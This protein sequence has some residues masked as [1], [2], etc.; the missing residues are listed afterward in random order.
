MEKWR[1][2]GEEKLAKLIQ[3]IEQHPLTGKIR[4][5]KAAETLTAR[6]EAAGQLQALRKEQAE[7]VGRLQ[8][9]V[10]EIERAFNQ[11]KSALA[12]ASREYTQ[13][14]T[15]CKLE[16]SGF[17]SQIGIQQRIL[18]ETHD[19]GIDEAILFFRT[20]LDWLR[21]PGRIDSRARSAERNIF[22]MSKQICRESNE[23]GVL[24][25][26]SYCQQAI[27]ALEEFTFCPEFDLNRVEQLKSGMP[28]IEIYEEITAE[29][30]LEKINNPALAG[31][32][33]A[34]EADW[35]LSKLGAKFD[36]VMGRLRF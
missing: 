5:D 9:S 22:T 25:A 16:N 15:S 33:S 11:A 7:A 32:I 19:P 27:K 8:A 4:Q 6:Q 17:E 20:K 18:S 14:H 12:I 2:E 3:T 28:S 29:K 30:P 36:K 23:G 31:C 21:A 1:Q 34:S 10:A 35:M 13:A 24:A 26:I